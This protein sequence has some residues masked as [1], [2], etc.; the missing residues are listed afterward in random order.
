M[1]DWIHLA[2]NTAHGWDLLS[3][4][5]K[6]RRGKGVIQKN[7]TRCNNIKIYYYIFI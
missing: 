5:R 1:M 4:R 6:F 7:L 3:A 2:D